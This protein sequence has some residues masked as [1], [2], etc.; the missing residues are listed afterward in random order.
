MAS[1]TA[2]SE[3]KSEITADPSQFQAGMNKAVASATQASAQIDAQ[4]KKIGDSVSKL[5]GVL[6][7]MTAVLAGGGAF[8]KFITDANEWNTTAGK[9]SAQLGV[10][11]EK[12]SVMQVAMARLGIDSETVTNASQRLSK[13]VQTNSQAFDVLGVSVRDSS[14]A[15]KPVT[16]LMAEVNAKLAAIQNPIEQNIAGQQIYGKG[17][18]E[19]RGILKLTSEAMTA[20]EERAK[21]LGLIVGPEGVKMSKQYTAQMR[22]LGLVGKSIEMQF[23]NALLPVFTTLGAFMSREGP[24]AGQ[25]FANVLRG[26]G[27][28]AASSWLALK[29]M[30]DGLGAIAAQAAALLSG[31]LA[32]FKAIGKARDEEAARNAAAYERLKADFS[33]PLQAPSIANADVSGGPRYNFKKDQTERAPA[34]EKSRMS[35]WEAQL[36]TA[37]AAITAQGLIE[38]QF[39]ER[40][41]AE[42]LSYWQQL[43]QRKDLSDS[44]RIAISKHTAAAEISMVRQTFDVR[45]AAL[46]AE[47]AQYKSNHEER[48]RI[49]LEIQSKY[50]EGTKE[51]EEASKRINQ[52][53][54][55][56]AAQAKTIAQ[57]RVDAER[58][59]RLQ[60]IKLEEQ[61]AKQEQALGF[62]TAAQALVGQQEF[63]QRRFEIA[64]EGVMERLRLA[65]SDP[66]RNPVEIANIHREIERLEQEHALRINA[67]KG[68]M[69]ANQLEPM[70]AV[71]QATE[72]AIGKAISG[73]LSRTMSLKQAMST[74]WQGLSQSII[75]EIAKIM[76]KKAAAWAV[77]KAMALAGIG[78]KAAEAGAGA[79]ASQASIPFAGPYLALAAMA[80]VFAGVM[81]MS[82]KVP[83]HSAAGGFDIPG[84]MSPIVQTHPR[85]MILPA[86]LSDT[87]RDMASQPTAG[88]GGGAAPVALQ[89]VSAGEFFI[90]ARKDLIRV[91]EGARR[92]NAWRPDR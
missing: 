14:G 31:D 26:I 70:L 35:T 71:Y 69:R 53:Q 25:A 16:D 52:V 46:H 40:S 55:E 10:T 21:Q 79:A 54:R 39:R 47:A 57:V 84:T 3:F 51:Y 60:I 28:V 92:D 5:N 58:E 49:E 88:P 61:A 74:I 87:I 9:M 56:A 37:K 83:S 48:L 86:R 36:E 30:G 7:G 11:T 13:S 85:E 41:L 68:D 75:G 73:I 12:A 64:R 89:G 82:S 17:W 32:G 15:Y 78:T 24:Q 23:G 22:D 6:M 90:A 50:A 59:A 29:D 20:A 27:F 81:G 91:L 42:N 4:F 33:A 8:K 76:A 67:I 34:A 62:T 2:N 80:T 44:E 45:V 63:E 38:G 19:V 66:D 77:E 72:A 65:E 43:A 1:S 18:Q